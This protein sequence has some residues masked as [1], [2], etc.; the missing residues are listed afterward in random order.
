[1]GY[2]GEDKLKEKAEREILWFYNKA[3]KKKSHGTLEPQAG[4][5]WFDEAR[6]IHSGGVRGE[7][8]RAM[9]VNDGHHGMIS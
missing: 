4:N 1:M 3:K 9:V 8:G 5:L 2:S 6:M 7:W